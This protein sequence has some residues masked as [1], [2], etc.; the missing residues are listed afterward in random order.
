MRLCQSA[1]IGFLYDLKNSLL[2]IL[3]YDDV[4]GIIRV[5]KKR[6]RFRMNGMKKLILIVFFMGVGLNAADGVCL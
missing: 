6:G 2:R 3:T 5:Y 1:F 4:P